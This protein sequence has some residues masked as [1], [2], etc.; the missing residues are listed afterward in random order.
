MAGS[1]RTGRERLFVC[2][3]ACSH[4][5]TSSIMT[6]RLSGVVTYTVLT[7]SLSLSLCITIHLPV[8]LL[9]LTHIASSHQHGVLFCSDPTFLISPFPPSSRFFFSAVVSMCHLAQWGLFSLPVSP[10]SFFSSHPS[11]F[12][13]KS[14]NHS[15]ICCTPLGPTF[16]SAPLFPAPLVCDACPWSSPP[17]TLL[18]TVEPAILPFFCCPVPQC[19][20]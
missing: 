12:E 17:F 3:L 11:I 13:L 9:L 1:G 10:L 8:S 7:L 20:G 14:C 16:S 5:L 19:S 18:Y 15:L 6:P 4:T 2:L